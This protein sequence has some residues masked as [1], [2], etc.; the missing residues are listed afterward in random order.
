MRRSLENRSTLDQKEAAAI[1][2]KANVDSA[3][4]SATSARQLTEIN[5][6]MQLQ[7]MQQQ[8]A[9]IAAEAKRAAAL[10]AS[11]SDTAGLPIA[12]S[13]DLSAVSQ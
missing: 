12:P 4:A 9:M 13:D 3:V 1:S 5:R 8:E 6:M 7:F 10:E 11:D 2:A